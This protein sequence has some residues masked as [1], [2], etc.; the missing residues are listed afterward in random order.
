MLK[1]RGR[2]CGIIGGGAVAQRRAA[3]LLSAGAEVTVDGV[4]T[5]GR[6]SMSQWVTGYKVRVSTDGASFTDVDGGGR[7]P[8]NTSSLSRSSSACRRDWNPR[9]SRWMLDAAISGST[10]DDDTAL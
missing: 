4:V 9:N 3:A 6:A 10:Y 5:Q 2:R 7:M 1:V 8:M